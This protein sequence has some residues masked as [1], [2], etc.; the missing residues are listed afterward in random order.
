MTQS[1]S[2]SPIYALYHLHRD[3]LVA[4]TNFSIQASELL[5]YYLRP[6]RRSMECRR[7]S[8]RERLSFSWPISSF[9]LRREASSSSIM[10]CS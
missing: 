3:A 7:L 4:S 5:V 1:T 8:E 10:A 6:G 9:T 2:L